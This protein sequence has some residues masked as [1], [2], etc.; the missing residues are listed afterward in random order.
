MS[1]PRV[2]SAETLDHLPA[3]DPAARR[4]RR[5]LLRVH[6]A[7][8][9]RATVCAGWQAL[10][11]PARAQRPLRILELGAGDGRLLLGVARTLR[12]PQVRLTLLDR[13]AL[14]SRPTLDG[15]A[16]LGWTAQ[17]HQADVHLWAD[18]AHEASP[19]WDLVSAALFLHHFE[20]AALAR[21]LAAIAARADRCFAVEP[22]RGWLA[23]AGSHLVGLLGV[24]AV[25]R[26]DA[27][28][29]VRAGFRT[30]ELSAAWP[31]AAAWQLHEAG[32][33]LFSHVFSARR[34][35]VAP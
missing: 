7:M 30:G 20:G 23:R 1:R 6:A 25:T 13:Q 32:A 9:T 34:A 18:E 31:G 33:G 17:V 8:R 2:V 35:E 19:R 21:L 15:Y 27:V 28:L 24:N 12:W 29:S 26:E 10:V 14:V 3:E 16:A 5:D 22:A 4:A 11:S